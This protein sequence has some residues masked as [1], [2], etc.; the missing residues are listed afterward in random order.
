MKKM[1]AKGVPERIRTYKVYGNT[2]II[3]SPPSA[4]IRNML[5]K[6]R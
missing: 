2:E 4:Q 5:R 6:Q 3:I 1:K